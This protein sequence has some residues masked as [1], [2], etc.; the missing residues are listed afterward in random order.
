M[1][2]R[3]RTPRKHNPSPGFI[4]D[5]HRSTVLVI[6]SQ[7]EMSKQQQQRRSTRSN[8]MTMKRSK[9]PFSSRSIFILLMILL[10]ITLVLSV[11]ILSA[12]LGEA[13][14]VLQ[15]DVHVDLSLFG[16]DVN[17]NKPNVVFLYAKYDA[18]L[19]KD[20]LVMI[21]SY[22]DRNTTNHLD[23]PYKDDEVNIAVKTEHVGERCV[24]AAKWQTDSY[25]TCNSFHEIS[26]QHY[27]EVTYLGQG[28][29]RNVWQVQDFGAIV[30]T[31]RLYR[32]FE[33][34]NYEMHRIDAIITERLTKSPHVVDIYGY[35]GQSVLN[36]LGVGDIASSTVMRKYKSSTKKLQLAYSLAAGIR[37][38]HNLDQDQ[39]RGAT[40]VHRDI[41]ASNVLISL[42][43][44]LKLN[45][46]NSA[47]LLYWDEANGEM[48]RLRD[49]RLCGQ[50]SR[51]ADTR[52]P[53]ECQG[54]DL[55]E[56]V[57]VYAI[58][59]VIF[60]LLSGVRMYHYDSKQASIVTDDDKMRELISRGGY[61]PKLP[62]NVIAS[63]DPAIVVLRVTMKQALTYDKNSRPT[64][65][66]IANYL[67]E[68]LKK[69]R[70]TKKEN[71]QT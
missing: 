14:S 24:P 48:C 15:K 66:K 31:L 36:E 42:D 71:Q 27:S 53:E 41:G 26:F 62:D 70:N 52:T 56:K 38:M 49:E 18:V 44:R 20:R 2:V 19:L 64:A 47:N 68:S 32:E 22:D 16:I 40:L 67:N 11:R 65:E 35:C 43:K 1:T 10:A 51:R 57:D 58:G 46:F 8:K 29:H 33:P 5:K 60:R 30:K 4:L 17:V 69:I 61:E 6:D 3:T 25:P 28:H 21:H 13:M 45:D 63:D 55:N 23:R 50:D 34:R 54:K 37:D 7:A 12:E 39:G 59:S 9:R